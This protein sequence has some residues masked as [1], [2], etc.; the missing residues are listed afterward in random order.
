MDDPHGRE[1]RQNFSAAPS[2]GLVAEGL[3]T[4]ELPLLTGR[5]VCKME[6]GALHSHLLLEAADGVYVLIRRL[7][8]ACRGC[9]CK[10]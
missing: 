2:K 10:M 6:Q 4:K 7:Q 3:L 9:Q 8:V 5:Q 1:V